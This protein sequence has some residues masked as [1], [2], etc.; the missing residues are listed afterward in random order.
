[1]EKLKHILCS[2]TKQILCSVTFSENGAVYETV[3]EY[4][5]ELDRARMTISYDAEKT[6][7]ACRITKARIRARAHTHTHTHTIRAHSTEYL[8]LFRGNNGLRTRLRVNIVRT[9]PALLTLKVCPQ[10][11]Y[12]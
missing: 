7:F 4:T 1:M 2:V 9:L 3:W 5:A 8:L 6:R 12:F 10:I 11:I